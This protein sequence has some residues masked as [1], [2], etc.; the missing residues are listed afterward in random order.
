MQLSYQVILVLKIDE[1][2]RKNFADDVLSILLLI[3]IF[4]V[5]FVEIFTPYL[6]FIIAPGFTE[7]EIK[8]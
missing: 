4:I 6:V 1:K 5:T 3:L 2:K 7:N 8:F